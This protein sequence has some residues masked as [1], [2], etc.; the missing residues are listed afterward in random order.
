M[1]EDD[2]S[3]WDRR[4][5]EH[6]MAPVADH[7]PPAPPVFEKVEQLFPTSG[8]AM[9]IA[10]GR[11]RG[12]VWLATRGMQMWAV[13]VSPVAIGLARQLASRSGVADRCRFSVVD[14]D[15]G[16]PDGPP[17]DL[18]LVHLFRD[19]RLD[20]AIIDRLAPGGLLAI[21]VRSEVDVG[22]GAFRV[23]PGELREAFSSLEVITDDEA[24]GMAWL[25]ARRPTTA[26]GAPERER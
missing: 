24:D 6:G 25:V 11:G 8:Q 7:D 2:R 26:A 10:C 18:V 16:L 13:D 12:A 3:H 5:A 20:Q 23:R 1:S 15:D 19:P 14:L 9:E 21:A 4:Y 22:P 17:V